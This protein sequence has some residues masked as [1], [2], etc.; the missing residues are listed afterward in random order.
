MQDIHF[1]GARGDR[2]VATGFGKEADPIVLLL[3][4]PGQGREMWRGA[5]EALAKAGRRAICLDLRGHGDSDHASDGAY[6]LNAYADDLK[7]VL[8][9]LSSRATVVGAGPSGVAA[10]VAVGE[11]EPG[12]VSAL[13]LVGVTAWVEPAV[14]A[15][16]RAA[17]RKRGEAFAD[18]AQVLAAIA[19]VHP[20]EPA[21]ASTERL[22][23]AYE[24]GADG[25]W[26][27]RGDPRTVNAFYVS[28]ETRRIEAAAA[29]IAVP[30][31]LIRGTLNEAVS[32][33][34]TQR[35]QAL[36]PGAE[37]QE[38]DGGGHYIVTDHEDAFNAILLEFLE[39]RAPRQP[40]AYQRGADPRL[41]RSILGCFG[42]GVTVVTT[43]APDGQPIGF[44]A[45]SFSSVS[46]EPPLVLFCIA[47]QS[48]NL[49]TFRDA[50]GFAINILHIG[51]Q[52]TSDRFARPGGSRFDGVTWEVRADG[53]API[54]VGSLASLDC[55][56]HAVHDGGD[57]LIIVGEVRH[58]DFEPHRD[59]LLYLHGK[60]RRV[61][62]A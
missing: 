47:R 17:A 55:A 2:L 49:A 1:S 42:T 10:I 56:T 32:E 29:R 59:P 3:P 37:R 57:H 21:P 31:T 60:Y 19:Q 52:P 15:R 33:A 27:W 11:S 18:S 61:H 54:I 41:L 45:N 28:T 34:A 5:S 46:L 24:R 14:A 22:L 8:G 58:A 20:F 51:Q 36:I 62:F 12:A 44:T 13:V 9:Q 35:L 26:R 38:I 4:A 43:F 23:K 50:H 7:A 16:I 30:T 39:R 48:R 25:L 6:D 53:G 40:L